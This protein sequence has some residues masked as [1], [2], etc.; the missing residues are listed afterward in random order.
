MPKYRVKPGKTFGAGGRYPAGSVVELTE[1]EAKGFLDKLEPVAND[2]TVG[3]VNE[4]LDQPVGLK[5]ELGAEV[6]ED[7][8][9][10]PQDEPVTAVT[11]A[12]EK[13]KPRTQRRRVTED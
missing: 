12:P 1:V 13:P 9:I 8:K 2:A 10:M 4:V 6:P 5:N 7:L 11:P 3:L